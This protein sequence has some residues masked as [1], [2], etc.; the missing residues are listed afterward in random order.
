[1]GLTKLIYHNDW[2][3]YSQMKGKMEIYIHRSIKRKIIIV[4]IIVESMLLMASPSGRAKWQFNDNWLLLKGA[5]H[6]NT[7]LSRPAVMGAVVSFQ[8][9][10][11]LFK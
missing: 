9:Q 6:K 10:Y 8:I 11:A 1:M 4:N 3:I 5:M 2:V 7:G